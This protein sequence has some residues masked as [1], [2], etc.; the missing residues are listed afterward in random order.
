MDDSVFG[1]FLARP[2]DVG[3]WEDVLVR[4]ELGPRALRIALED[5][6]GSDGHL[7]GRFAW[8]ASV[9]QRATE[10]LEAM[11]QGGVVPQ[12]GG[13]MVDPPA[14]DALW[15]LFATYAAARAANFA[16]LQR[17]GLGVWEWCAT[18]EHGGE[19]TAHQ[20]VRWLLEVDSRVL[21][22]V[23]AAPREAASC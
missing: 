22:E 6:R 23:R 19:V 15:R 10:A 20:L 3:E 7:L 13:E 18:L 8:L 2:S 21:A 16:A 11:R 4:L 12:R 17:R 5:R 1:A 9:E 14:P